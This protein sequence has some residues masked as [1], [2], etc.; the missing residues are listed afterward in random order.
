MPVLMISFFAGTTHF[1]LF[2][3][4]AEKSRDLF[5]ESSAL[6]YLAE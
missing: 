4:G 6:Q 2:V 5:K 3:H 1:N